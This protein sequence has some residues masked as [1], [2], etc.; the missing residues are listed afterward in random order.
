MGCLTWPPAASSCMSCRPVPLHSRPASSFARAAR[1]QAD[2]SARVRGESAPAARCGCALSDHDDALVVEL[3]LT[4]TLGHEEVACLP[5]S[6]KCCFQDSAYGPA[7][8]SC[9]YCN[10]CATLNLHLEATAS[11]CT[12]TSA[13][14][15]IEIASRL[16]SAGWISATSLTTTA[17]RLRRPA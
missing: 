17:R 14:I 11:C 15:Q 2:L 1:A 4:P 13:V 8:R 3:M 5:V 10:S 12:G 16:C 6:I 9:A 7:L